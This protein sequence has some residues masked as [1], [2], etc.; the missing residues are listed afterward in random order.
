MLL[1]IYV[2]HIRPSLC[3]KIAQAGRTAG[4]AVAQE[5]MF[6]LTFDGK[7]GKMTLRQLSNTAPLRRYPT[8]QV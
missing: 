1:R 8:V 6:F 4:E 2:E 7:Q 3:R 5:E